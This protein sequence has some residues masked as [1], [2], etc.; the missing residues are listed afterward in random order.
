MAV[1]NGNHSNFSKSHA[2]LCGALR[3][4]PARHRPRGAI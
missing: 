3:Q 1:A 4:C 2:M